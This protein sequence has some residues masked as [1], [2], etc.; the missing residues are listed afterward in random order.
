MAYTIV[1]MALSASKIKP[2]PTAIEEVKPRKGQ[3]AIWSTIFSNIMYKKINM[4]KKPF[5][6]SIY[7]YI[8]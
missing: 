3:C 1:M 5:Q 8:L 2:Y 6:I 7:M 4:H